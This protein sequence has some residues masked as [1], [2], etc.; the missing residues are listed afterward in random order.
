MTEEPILVFQESFHYSD[1]PNVI[2][3]NVEKIWQLVKPKVT[4]ER[5]ISNGTDA[6]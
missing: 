1:G 6:D 3:P 2:V 4:S 5:L